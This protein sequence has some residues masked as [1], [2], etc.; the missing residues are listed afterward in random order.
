[1]VAVIACGPRPQTFTTSK[2]THSPKR[3]GARCRGLIRSTPCRKSHAQGNLCL[4]QGTSERGG[5]RKDRHSER[6]V[7][8]RML[9]AATMV[10]VFKG[11]YC[12]YTIF[13]NIEAQKASKETTGTHLAAST[14][15]PLCYI[16]FQSSFFLRR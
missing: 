12:C 8:K 2:E 16:S 5:D 14:K 7:S 13:L 11:L 3:D 9:P 6:L 4:C 10:H 1:M 15:T